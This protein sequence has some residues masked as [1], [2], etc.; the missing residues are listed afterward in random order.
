MWQ[1]SFLSSGSGWWQFGMVKLSLL[2]VFIV[3]LGS[4]ELNVTGLY[5]QTG[6]LGG[7]SQVC[8]PEKYLQHICRHWGLKN[9]LWDCSNGSPVCCVNAGPL[10][11]WLVSQ[12]DNGCCP[13][14]YTAFPHMARRERSSGKKVR[15]RSLLIYLTCPGKLLLSH[16]VSFKLCLQSFYLTSASYDHFLCPVYNNKN[17]LYAFQPSFSLPIAQ[18]S[19]LSL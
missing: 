19:L 5:F 10:P 3:W 1:R 18:G 14:P 7:T 9:R 15:G 11:A 16:V 17:L 13:Q 4:K 8:S 6:F 12:R 2:L